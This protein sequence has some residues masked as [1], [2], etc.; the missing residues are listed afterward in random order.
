MLFALITAVL[1][2]DLAVGIAVARSDLYEP[3]QKRFQY[4]LIG[5]VPVIGALIVWFFL[6][7]Q[8]REPAARNAELSGNP[9]LWWNEPDEHEGQSS[10]HGDGDGG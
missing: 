10:H 1:L 5:L 6:R 3:R 7:E 2:L 8:S 9:Y 4:L